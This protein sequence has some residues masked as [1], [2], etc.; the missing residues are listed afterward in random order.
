LFTKISIKVV[1][2][3]HKT[4][5][6]FNTLFSLLTLFGIID[7]V[8]AITL[9]IVYLVRK[10]EIC[11][12][13]LFVCHVETS[14]TLVP[15][16]M[17]LVHYWKALWCVG[18]HQDGFTMFRPMV[19]ELLCVEQF[20]HW[21]FNKIKTKISGKLGWALGIVEK[22]STNMIYEGDPIIFEPKVNG[23]EFWLV[24]VNE[25]LIKVLKLIL[26]QEISDPSH[27]SFNNVGKK[28]MGSTYCIQNCENLIHY[29]CLLSTDG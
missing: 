17:F 15:L 27:T 23:I 6:Y 10:P 3:K 18:V 26:E 4:V 8:E 19:Q 7:I 2:W 25:N 20:R 14:K 22:P 21:K 13:V 5:W 9:I 12:L 16:A 1:N 28:I 29:L 24:L 11:L